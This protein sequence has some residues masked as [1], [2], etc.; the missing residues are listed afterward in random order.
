MTCLRGGRH[1]LDEAE[2]ALVG[3]LGAGGMA[4]FLN[5]HELPRRSGVSSRMRLSATSRGSKN[6]CAFSSIAGPYLPHRGSRVP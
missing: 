2:G 3:A 4:P 5:H 1:T 6:G